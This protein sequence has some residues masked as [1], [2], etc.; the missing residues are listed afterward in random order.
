[1]VKAYWW[2]F[3]QK[4]KDFEGTIKDCLKSK[5]IKFRRFKRK[6]YPDFE[7]WKFTI[8]HNV[9]LKHTGTFDDGAFDALKLHYAMMGDKARVEMNGRVFTNNFHR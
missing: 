4:T 6:D 3:G 1:M 9:V 8:P 7:A 5:G 2:N